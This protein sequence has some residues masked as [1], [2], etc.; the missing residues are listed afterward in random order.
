MVRFLPIQS[1]GINGILMF[2]FRRKISR[3]AEEHFESCTTLS[4]IISS[5][6][7]TVD[8]F[9]F[10]KSLVVQ[11]I[12][13]FFGIL[14]LYVSY[15]ESYSVVLFFQCLQA[16]SVQDRKGWLFN[17]VTTWRIPKGILGF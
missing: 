3:L 9:S 17:L 7:R 5:L 1:F 4:I 11:V 16:L 10:K 8:I 6:R 14:H 15:S 12:F 13:Q 2:S